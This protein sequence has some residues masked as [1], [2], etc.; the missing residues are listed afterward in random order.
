MRGTD[1]SRC[2]KALGCNIALS[3]TGIAGPGG[4]LPGKPV[5]LCMRVSFRDL[6]YSFRLQIDRRPRKRLELPLARQFIAKYYIW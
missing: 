1:G 2:L 3:V 6:S 4:A 5:V